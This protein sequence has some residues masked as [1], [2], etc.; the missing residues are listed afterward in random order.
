M[1]DNSNVRTFLVLGVSALICGSSA[2]QD[3]ESIRNILERFPVDLS[4]VEQKR[5]FAEDVKWFIG[6]RAKN[7]VRDYE[8]MPEFMTRFGVV[9]EK[10]VKTLGREVRPLRDADIVRL[11]K[12]MDAAY[13]DNEASFKEYYAK[14][15]KD[16]AAKKEVTA[17][18]VFK[19]MVQFSALV[20]ASSPED[21]TAV[22][23]SSYIYPVCRKPESKNR[24]L[25]F[26]KQL[27]P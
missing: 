17:S 26:S 16:D 11:T 13:R 2:A 15:L 20:Y 10:A 22:A 7:P 6:A 5:K 8:E 14:K 23:K 25:E 24:F 1:K 12:A 19:I 21:W 4:K 9:Y 18:H 3:R 27:R